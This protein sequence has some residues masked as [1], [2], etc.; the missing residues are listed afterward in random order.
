MS[1]ELTLTVVRRLEVPVGEAWISTHESP[2][3]VVID[4]T[5]AERLTALTEGIIVRDQII[6]RLRADFALARDVV[7]AAKLNHTSTCHHFPNDCAL[8]SA[9]DA[10]EAS[11]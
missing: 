6:D 2:F 8:C 3:P 9:V 10:F 4:P 11:L 5:A 1:N 7:D